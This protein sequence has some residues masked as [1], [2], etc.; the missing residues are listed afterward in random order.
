MLD[1]GGGYLQYDGKMIHTDA[2]KELKPDLFT[3]RADSSATI[4]TNFGTSFPR[5]AKKG[6][7]FVRVDVLPN[8]VYKFDSVKWIE[9]NKNLTDTYLDPEYIEFLITKIDNG[10][11]DLDVLSDN[12]RYQIEEYLKNQKS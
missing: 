4:S 10:E 6:D 2:L 1:V 11:Y 7:V 5:I 9:L 3:L 8:K 12:E